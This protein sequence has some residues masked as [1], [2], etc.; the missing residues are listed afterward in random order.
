MGGA[1]TSTNSIQ[2]RSDDLCQLGDVLAGL[3]DSPSYGEVAGKLLDSCRLSDYDYSSRL[4]REVISELFKDK[5]VG[6]SFDTADCDQ[7]EGLVREHWTHQRPSS[8][9][10]QRSQHRQDSLAMDAEISFNGKRCARIPGC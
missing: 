8:A 9:L 3:S 2:T 6:A 5:E 10:L 1:S 4:C 7:V